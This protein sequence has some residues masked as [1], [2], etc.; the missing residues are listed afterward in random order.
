MFPASWLQHSSKTTKQRNTQLIRTETNE[1]S[2]AILKHE[3]QLGLFYA[4]DFD[5]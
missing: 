4:I 3:Q 5:Y 1:M 2:R